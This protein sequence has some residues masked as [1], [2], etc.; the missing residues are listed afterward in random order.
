MR[1]L[2]KMPS[3]LAAPVLTVDAGKMHKVDPRNVE[4]LFGMWTGK[5]HTRPPGKHAD[6]L[7]CESVFKVRRL[8]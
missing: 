1:L 2:S 5:C 4:S 8:N 3:R 6:Q 7:T